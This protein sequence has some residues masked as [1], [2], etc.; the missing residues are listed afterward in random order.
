MTEIVLY[1]KPGCCLCDKVKVQLQKVRALEPFSLKEVNILQD[2]EAYAKYHEEIP[3]VLVNGR[4]T[5]KYHLDEGMLLQK[6][7]SLPT[8]GE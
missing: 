3:V 2:S 8:Q 4:K 5:F 7:R 6:L 1:T